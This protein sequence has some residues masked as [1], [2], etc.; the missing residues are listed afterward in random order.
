MGLVKDFRDFVT[1]FSFPDNMLGFWGS[2]PSEA[3]VTVNEMS[4]MQSA[5]VA[6]CIR[7]IS[8]ALASL[9]LNIYQMDDKGAKTVAYDHDLQVILNNQPNPETDS[10]VFRETL[11]IHLL[12][13]G[14]CYMEKV[15]DNGGRLRYLYQR[16]PFR[17]FPYRNRDGVLA[18][19]TTDGT[20]RGQERI[21][22]AEDMIHLKGMSLDGLVGMNPI[23][24]L[25][26]ETLGL[27]IAARAHGARL[28]A[29]GSNPSGVLS[30][31]KLL[32]EE[33][34][35]KMTNTWQQG[36]SGTQAHKF[37][38][39]DGGLKWQ[40]ISLSPEQSQ[41]LL[42]RQF[43]RGDIAAIYGVPPHLLGDREETRANIEQQMLQFLTFTMGPWLKRWESALNSKLIQN[44]G[45][46]AC[47]FQ[48]RFDT[49]E[50][51]RG[52]YATT[53]NGIMTGRQ[54]GIYTAN[55]GR[56]ILGLNPSTDKTA[57]DRWMPVNMMDADNPINTNEP[58]TDS[59]STDGAG[60]DKQDKGTN[61]VSRALPIYSRLFRDAFGRVIAR[62]KADLKA[63]TRAFSPVL[64]A[65]AD[66][67]YMEADAERSAGDQP[68]QEISAFV[69]DYVGGMVKRAAEWT[70]EKADAQSAAELERSLRAIKI[71]VF[72]DVA[73]EK[74]KQ[75]KEPT[76]E[77]S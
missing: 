1:A 57:D 23:K 71:A 56:A 15:Y 24:T 49:S 38:I 41:F 60:T 37:A 63:I 34:K 19:K 26:R 9:P 42:T 48:I 52:D 59:G 20:E 77:Q 14:N 68:T 69:A 13:A 76:D 10:F 28:F 40:Q 75:T 17:T 64:F 21:I 53:L 54:W 43:Q 30:T 39:L 6:G 16:S 55:E 35:K 31:D 2:A 74:A 51:K 61:D 36:H 11:Q 27:D 45:R 47:K 62:D 7:V 44:V 73:T 46:N 72:R 5:A 25:A 33:T 3:G 12:L 22:L 65:S 8:G 58:A 67:F 4:A 32:K 29:N 18:F 50:M 70:A 66:L